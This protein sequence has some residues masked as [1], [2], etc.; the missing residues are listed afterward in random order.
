MLSNKYIQ[1]FAKAMVRVVVFEKYANLIM[2]STNKTELT[3]KNYLITAFAM[4]I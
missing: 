1:S 3:S 4:L 2:M